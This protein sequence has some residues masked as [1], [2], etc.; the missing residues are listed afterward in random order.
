MHIRNIRWRWQQSRAR[1]LC[2]HLHIHIKTNSYT[3]RIVNS[4]SR[5]HSITSSLHMPCNWARRRECMYRFIEVS[6]SYKVHATAR[7]ARIHCNNSAWKRNVDRKWREREK[8]VHLLWLI[9]NILCV[10]IPNWFT[11]ILRALSKRLLHHSV[12][13]IIHSFVHALGKR[14]GGEEEQGKNTIIHSHT[15]NEKLHLDELLS[16]VIYSLISICRY[17]S[18]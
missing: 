14:G 5:Q 11:I 6:L 17:K 4:L 1:E 8:T 7:A 2:M 15:H 13:Y 3:S 12:M 9:G 16:G 10:G 18:Y